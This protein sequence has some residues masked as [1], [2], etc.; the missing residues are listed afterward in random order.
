MLKPKSKKPTA[1]L[2]KRRLRN[3]LAG[4]AEL[5][6]DAGCELDFNNP[7]ELLVAT[8]LSAQCTDK[9][10]NAVTPALFRKYPDL[11]AYARA[12]P[13]GVAKIIR[14][15]GLYRNKS[16]NIVAAARMIR[17]ECGRLPDTIAE[18]V[19]LPGVGRKTA[20][21]ILVNAYGRPGIMCDTHCLRLCRRLG[22]SS[23]SA[24]DKLELAL[25]GLLPEKEW[26]AFSHRIIWHGRRVCHARKPAC[27]EC[28]LRRWCAYGQES[29]LSP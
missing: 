27:G 19:K 24:P 22:L 13:A 16:R 17:D 9:K 26:S 20:N 3:I 21:C 4:L 7:L 12:R 11:A 14:P 25:K 1:V 10:V 6:P 28:S 23:E 8:I 15:L 18:L 2:T 5:Y 29:G